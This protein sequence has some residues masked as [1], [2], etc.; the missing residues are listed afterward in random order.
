MSQVKYHWSDFLNAAFFGE[1]LIFLFTQFFGLYLVVRLNNL[2]KLNVVA[3]VDIQPVYFLL[4]FSL[5]TAGLLILIKKFPRP[6]VFQALFFLAVFEGLSN[7]G[8]GFGLQPYLFALVLIVAY[9]A[10]YKLYLHNLILAL[11][12]AGLSVLVATS[13][14]VMSAIII[15]IFLAIYDYVA[16]NKTKH[17][18]TMFKGMAEKQVFFAVIIPY[19]IS[20]YKH[21]LNLVKMGQDYLFLGTGDLAVPLIFLITVYLNQP[22]LAG[23]VLLGSFAGLIFL[24]CQYLNRHERKA[25]PGLPALVGGALLGYFLGYFLG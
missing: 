7:V 5:L 11:A 19:K 25:L 17:M 21:S 8:R 14:S 18:V 9:L 20:S 16:V 24:Y 6:W 23:W 22:A 15:L 12:I 2:P 13:T 1:A 3:N 4:A 10:V